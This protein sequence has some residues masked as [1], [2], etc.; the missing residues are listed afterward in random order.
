MLG[1]ATGEE[2]EM[3]AL[4]MLQ[5]AVPQMVGVVAS[6]EGRMGGLNKVIGVATATIR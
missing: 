1:A 4:D 6:K 2:G 5:E 3:E